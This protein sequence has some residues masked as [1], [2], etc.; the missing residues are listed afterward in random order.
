M[1]ALK[2]IKE[3]KSWPGIAA[4]MLFILILIKVVF[5]VYSSSQKTVTFDKGR[6]IAAFASALE[7]KRTGDAETKV[8]TGTFTRAM[9]S[10]LKEASLK[11]NWLIVPKNAVYAGALDKTDELMPLIAEKMKKARKISQRGSL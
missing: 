6:A 11:N 7:R 4:F 5:G 8:L 2:F 3:F 9:N 10:A 1:N